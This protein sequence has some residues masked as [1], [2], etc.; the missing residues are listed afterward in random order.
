MNWIS[1]FF[2]LSFFL[3]AACIVIAQHRL[4]ARFIVQ[5]SVLLLI[6]CTIT[7]YNYIEII[8]KINHDH[9]WPT[10][11]SHLSGW[12]YC[13]CL[14]FFFC[15]SL[16]IRR[17]FYE[18]RYA[19]L[20]HRKRQKRRWPTIWLWKPL[21]PYQSSSITI[22]PPKNIWMNRNRNGCKQL[23]QLNADDSADDQPPSHFQV[24]INR[25]QGFFLSS[26]R[27]FCLSLSVYL[28]RSLA[29]Y[30]RWTIKID[31]MNAK[32]KNERKKKKKKQRFDTN[33][34]KCFDKLV[35]W[36]RISGEWKTMNQIYIH[37]SGHNVELCLTIAKRSTRFI[38]FCCCCFRCYCC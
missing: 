28:S 2:F 38:W 7:I 21:T 10:F 27:F 6:L 18:M 32:K 13:F 33:I 4:R 19:I 24:V 25:N 35:R 12:H 15:V 17:N 9:L 8:I 20:S 14:H 23:Q 30:A 29:L 5:G 37:K 11:Q 36:Y 3:F 16:K 26:Q 1:L 22:G 34:P 31:E